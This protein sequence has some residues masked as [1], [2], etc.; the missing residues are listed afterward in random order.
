MQITIEIPND[1]AEDLASSHGGNAPLSV[2]ETLALAGYRF[3][4]LTQ[5]Q[6]RRL[7]GLEHRLDVEAFLKTH[8]VP[9]DYTE[10]D[11]CRD[12][13]THRRLGL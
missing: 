1:I 6:V 8:H 10:E 2:L 3:G 11:L 13:D 5:A 4:D 7:L 12:R 9:P